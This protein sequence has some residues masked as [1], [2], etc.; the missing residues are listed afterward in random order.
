[1]RNDASKKARSP[2]YSL[3]TERDRAEA[4]QPPFRERLQPHLRLRSHGEAF[5]LGLCRAWQELAHKEA[6]SPMAFSIE[7]AAMASKRSKRSR[8]FAASRGPA[9]GPIRSS[10]GLS[11]EGSEVPNKS[12]NILNTF[13]L[14]K[15]H[16]QGASA[17]SPPFFLRR[18]GL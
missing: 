1:M 9:E 3:S 18:D 5:S 8:G 6:K 10:Y 4:V 7:A 17:P 16:C 2:P 15:S 11:F 14:S 13:G 12:S